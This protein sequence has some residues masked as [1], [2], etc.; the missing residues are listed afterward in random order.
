MMDEQSEW[1]TL[2]AAISEALNR[3]GKM[4]ERVSSVNLPGYGPGAKANQEDMTYHLEEALNH[5]QYLKR[6]AKDN[7]R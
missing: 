1:T 5:A 4:R 3:A 7:N 6:W 2:V